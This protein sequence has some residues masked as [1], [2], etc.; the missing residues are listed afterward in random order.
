MDSNHCPL[1][2]P[3]SSL[4]T[5]HVTL[6]H[7]TINRQEYN[8][9]L[10][11]NG[12]ETIA[13]N[14][15]RIVEKFCPWI[16]SQHCQ[17]KKL[18][19][20]DTYG[21]ESTASDLD[22]FLAAN[23]TSRNGPIVV[24]PPQ[25]ITREVL[26][27]GAF[28]CLH[29][30]DDLLRH[31]YIPLDNMPFAATSIVENV[32]KETVD[33]SMQQVTTILFPL[34]E[35]QQQPI[36]ASSDNHSRTSSTSH[37]SSKHDRS[38]D[39]ERPEILESTTNHTT[40]GDTPMILQ[41]EE[42]EQILLPLNNIHESETLLPETATTIIMDTDNLLQQQEQQKQS[43]SSSSGS[44]SSSTSS[45]NSSSS[46]SSSDNHSRTSSTS[47]KSS[48]HDRSIDSERPE[49][50]ESTTNH[51]T[52]GDTP[53]IL[54]QEETEQILLP[55]NNIHE[56]ETLLPETATTIIMDTDNL[57][58]QQE[59]Q[60][61]SSSS[62]SGSSSSS[63]SSSNS[64]S[65]SSSSSSSGS[66]SSST[67]SSTSSKEEIDGTKNGTT[68]NA[69]NA[70]ETS[71]VPIEETLKSS[72]NTKQKQQQPLPEMDKAGM[73][74]PSSN[75]TQQKQQQP[76]PK[77]VESV[78]K[79]NTITTNSYSKQRPLVSWNQMIAMKPSDPSIPFWSPSTVTQQPRL[80]NSSSPLQK[81]KKD[82]NSLP[83]ATTERKQKPDHLPL[84]DIPAQKKQKQQ[85][86]P[87]KNVGIG[88]L[89]SATI[90]TA[91]KSQDIKTQTPSFQVDTTLSALSVVALKDLCRTYKIS[92]SGTK[93]DLISRIANYRSKI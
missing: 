39:S 85:D 46:S 10:A 24:F 20:S 34:P 48:K 13:A 42:T 53:M 33:S 86:E 57:L 35:V 54:Q 63:T 69:S 66:G 58:Q 55:L 74:T 81:K 14:T 38:I 29:L 84:S 77:I 65:S 73:N 9:P 52:N 21:E 92:V 88:I 31:S 50:L 45:S 27:C 11:L 26:C 49:I 64:S 91:E 32:D 37:K 61:Q 17:Q 25:A 8:F 75:T 62:S 71:D 47:H 22:V 19:Y 23:S 5:I 16:F 40:N 44:S 83:N 28:V 41:Q 80:P 90:N 59:Q 89:A 30:Q 68:E 76:P 51:T 12:L 82:R 67:P 7:I 70:K 3:D 18:R 6:V 79:N 4:T 2:H 87:A 15:Q 36:E 72:V 60:K 1:F 78:A 43:S 93:Q 56:S